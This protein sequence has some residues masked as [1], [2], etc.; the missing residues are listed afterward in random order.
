MKP[1]STP[2]HLPEDASITSAPAGTARQHAFEAVPS[3]TWKAG[4]G[5]FVLASVIRKKAVRVV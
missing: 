3:R 2:P 5:A 4:S 1:Q